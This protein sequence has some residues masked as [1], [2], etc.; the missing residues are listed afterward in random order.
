MQSIYRT[1]REHAAHG[2]RDGDLIDRT[3]AQHV[4][5][6]FRSA[7][8][9]VVSVDAAAGDAQSGDALL[10][11]YEA[12]HVQ[13]VVTREVCEVF[14]EVRDNV[15]TDIPRYCHFGVFPERQTGQFVCVV[16]V[17]AVVIDEEGDDVSF[18]DRAYLS[19]SDVLPNLTWQT[20]L[21]DW[22]AAGT[23]H[24]NELVL[25]TQSIK[26]LKEIMSSYVGIVRSN[27]RLKR[28]TIT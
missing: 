27:V 5:V 3:A 20:D 21:P 8:Q 18:G 16:I 14:V 15:T 26:E 2:A 22:D 24:P 10:L 25:I 12:G 11:G 7:V 6:G 23:T 28:A 17:V 13:R 9:I 4:R 19:V 1:A